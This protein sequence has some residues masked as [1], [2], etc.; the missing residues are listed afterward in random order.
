[1]CLFFYWKNSVQINWLAHRV[2]REPLTLATHIQLRNNDV[3][4][5]PVLMKMG[6]KY[7]FH[8][9]NSSL[10]WIV[11]TSGFWLLDV[12]NLKFYVNIHLGIIIIDPTFCFALWSTKLLLHEKRPALYSITYWT[13][14]NGVWKQEMITLVFLVPTE[15]VI[16]WQNSW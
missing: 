1:M 3:W 6:C 7:L 4:C 2:R 10:L 11:K 12:M 9:K 13:E 16:D 15:L 14:V 8:T 5:S